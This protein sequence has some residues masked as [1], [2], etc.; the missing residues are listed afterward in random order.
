MALRIVTGTSHLELARAAADAAGV[1]LWP[2]EVERFPD[3]EMRPAVG[4]VRGDD[5]FVVHS[6]G[7]PIDAHI[8][9]MLLLLD[10]CR[11]AGAARVTAVLPYVAYARQDRRTRP[12]EAVGARVVLDAAGAAGAD[13][14]VVVD[15]HTA[16]L[17]AMS[18]VP[19]EMLTAVPLLAHALRGIDDDTAIVAPDLGAAKLAERYGSLLHRPVAVVR[20]V[21][22]SGAEVKAEEVVGEVEGR[23]CLLVD[24][25][26]STGATIEAAAG[27][28]VAHGAIGAVLVAATHGL[29]VGPALDRL[30]S[31]VFRS[32]VVTDTVRAPASPNVPIKI[33]SVAPL[34]GDAIGRMHRDEPL[35]DLLMTG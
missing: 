6:L 25:M 33:V 12:G 24:D 14:L 1:S 30:S 15:P 20:K 5:V 8:V 35:D 17:E 11:R 18:P 7:P 2:C 26:I 10:A 28:L 22:L 32:V 4:G 21:R 13:R 9:E 3:G 16:A 31:P 29:F 27:A 23:R 19:M 34:L